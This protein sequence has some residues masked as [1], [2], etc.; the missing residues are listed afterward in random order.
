MKTFPALETWID[1]S[2]LS[3]ECLASLQRF[4]TLLTTNPEADY[5][6]SVEQADETGQRTDAVFLVVTQDLDGENIPFKQ[7][8]VR[9]LFFPYENTFPSPLGFPKDIA[10]LTLKSLCSLGSKPL[11][12]ISNS[13]T[14]SLLKGEL[15]AVNSA[16]HGHTPPGPDVNTHLT[17][18]ILV[19]DGKMGINFETKTYA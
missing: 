5:N 2:S 10:Y 7:T 14:A 1:V 3:E 18:T 17:T 19:M 15:N 11:E 13:I 4:Y 9:M 8:T 12:L 16:I 6:V